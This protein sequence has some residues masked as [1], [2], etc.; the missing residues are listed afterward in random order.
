MDFSLEY[1]PEQERF[2]E[3][4]P[5]STLIRQDCM[6]LLLHSRMGNMMV[7]MKSPGVVTGSTSYPGTGL[8]AIRMVKAIPGPL[9]RIAAWRR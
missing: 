6:A 2:T 3:E 5:Y 7:I 1:T 4:E 9:F 8:K